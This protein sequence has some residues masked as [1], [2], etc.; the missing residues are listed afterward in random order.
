MGAITFSLTA[1]PTGASLSGNTLTWTPT[2]AQSRIANQFSVTATDAKGGSASQTWSVTPNGTIQIKAVFTYWTATG[3]VDINRVWLAGQ[4]YPAALV[5]Q[6]DGFLTRLQ[7]AANPDGTFGIPDVPAGFYWLQLSP[8]QTYWTSTSDFDAGVDVVGS[9]L[10][11]TTQSTTTIN[12]SLSG[13][14]PIQQGDLFAIQSNARGFELSLAGGFL[15]TTGATTL[16]ITVPL[17]PIIDF[18]SVNTLFF[19]QMEPVTSGGFSGLALGPALTQSSGVTITNGATNNISATLTPSPQKSIPLNIQG[20][21]WAN[22]YQN[23]APAAPTPLLTD[24]SVSAQPFVTDRIATGLAT[25]LGPNLT[26]LVPTGPSS[27]RSF[28]PL[29]TCGQSS[30]PL[31]FPSINPPPPPILTDQDFG[32]IS[33]GD[34]YPSSWP[35][36]F[37]FCQHATVQL[38]RPN[39]TLTDTFVLTFGETTPLPTTPIAPLVGPVQNPMING[40][41]FFQSGSLSTTAVNLSW[42]APTGAQPFGYY[43]SVFQLATL[44]TGTTQYAIVARFGTTKTSM[45]VP[46]LNSGSTYVFQIVAGVDGIANIETSPFR[47]HLPIAHSTV[48][49]A[50]ITIN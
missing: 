14:D 2:R 4:P 45:S 42:T 1:G 6:S 18:S 41:S 31:L 22:D 24:F 40:A 46:L 11:I 10:K 39:S 8:V 26:M 27:S 34:P 19:R 35:R 21:A 38:P 3:T 32:T 16:N 50:P 36:V 48:L 20:S 43:V 37:Q 29:Y 49:S 17:N 44:L 12:V 28:P 23:V 7:G 33:F 30:G 5:P 25:I 15:G 9:P 47:S 13:L